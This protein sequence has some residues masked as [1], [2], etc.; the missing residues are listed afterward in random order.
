MNVQTFLDF[1]YGMVW[2]KG[3]VFLLVGAG[4]ILLAAARLYPL[5]HP[6]EIIKKT[7]FSA[8]STNEEI[9]QFDAMATALGGTM[10]VGNIIGVAAALAIGGEGALFWLWAAGVCG[11]MLKYG[12]VFL[13]VKYRQYSNDGW[14]GGP[15]YYIKYGMGSP[16]LAVLFA[17]CCITG[18]F[19]M[20]NMAQANAA[21]NCLY[22]LSGISEYI[23]SVIICA[24]TTLV[25]FG[26]MKRIVKVSS[27]AVPLMSAL[28]LG[29]ALVILFMQHEHLPKAI[30]TIFKGAFGIKAAGGASA[31]I[32]WQAVQA[33]ITKGIFTN[34]AGLGSASIAHACAGECDPHKQGLWGMFEVFADTLLVCTLTGLV[35][36][37]SG[38]KY[39]DMS[40]ATV[41]AA[42]FSAVLGNVG[43]VIVQLSVV[44][45]AFASMLSWCLY[46]E[47]CIR[48]LG[49]NKKVITVY[50]SFFVL[51]A[52]AGGVVKLELVWKLS[53]ILNGLMLFPNLLAV[54]LL[55]PMFLASFKKCNE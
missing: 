29:G 46:G 23:L 37:T 26:G 25:I 15:M 36:I 12:E 10:G 17:A 14:L 24:L 45:F 31:A 47:R 48:F 32:M 33:G 34:E 30:E 38:I 22:E 13:A 7:I 2:G 8:K 49:G 1:C 42:A 55:S 54:C 39:S 6:S 21:V 20:G 27:F 16:A 18:S 50:R 52:A 43:G 9:S 5:R 3:T 51:A 19:G 28:Y 44:F 53:D 11:L 35:I 41:T 40:A 4:L